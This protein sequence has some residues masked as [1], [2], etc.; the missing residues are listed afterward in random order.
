MINSLVNSLGDVINSHPAISGFLSA[1]AYHTARN[2]WREC[3]G[4]EGLKQFFFT[5]TIQPKPPEIPAST[6]TTP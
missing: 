1:H 4:I 2:F 5:G 6:K 3:R